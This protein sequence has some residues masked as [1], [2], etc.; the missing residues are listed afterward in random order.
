MHL[1]FKVFFFFFFFSLTV[2]SEG[3]GRLRRRGVG[4][5]LHMPA[6]VLETNTMLRVHF[7][8]F[9]STTQTCHHE[10]TDGN[11]LLQQHELVMKNLMSEHGHKS[12]FQLACMLLC[13][14]QRGEGDHNFTFKIKVVARHKLKTLKKKNGSAVM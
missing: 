11:I 12:L 8:A 2:Y 6:C 14:K 7:Q 4:R 13:Y 1:Y 10:M 5:T 3:T 9:Q